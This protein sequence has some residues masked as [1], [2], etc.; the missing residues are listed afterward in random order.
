MPPV[1]AVRTLPRRTGRNLAAVEL[2]ELNA[3]FAV[4]AVATGAKAVMVGA[5]S[6]SGKLS[7]TAVT[8]KSADVWFARIVTV[9]GT[10]TSV[11]S[12]EERFTTRSLAVATARVTVPVEAGLAAL[13]EKEAPRF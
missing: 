4:P 2:V 8:L 13:S 12:L 3:A 11:V 6:P 10:V 5:L 1:E 7:S 9:A